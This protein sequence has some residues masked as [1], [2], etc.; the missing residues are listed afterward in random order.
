MPLPIQH[1]SII[2]FPR[3]FIVWFKSI[4]AKQ[5]DLKTSSPARSLRD[6][7]RVLKLDLSKSK[8]VDL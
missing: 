3:K 6:L 4:Y 1:M 7:S 8:E 5:V 2:F